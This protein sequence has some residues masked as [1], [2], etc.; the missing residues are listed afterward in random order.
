MQRGYFHFH[1]C[2]TTV[3]SPD[4]LAAIAH[5]K[6][7]SDLVAKI[8]DKMIKAELPLKYHI[9][10]AARELYPKLVQ[11]LAHNVSA[12]IP[13][14]PSDPNYLDHIHTCVNQK[15]VHSWKH[16]DACVRP[17]CPYCRMAKGSGFCDTTG[18][19][20]VTVKM[21]EEDTHFTLTV[22]P[23]P[24]RDTPSSLAHGGN[25]K[26]CTLPSI[27]SRAICFEL[28]RRKINLR[29]RQGQT[30]SHGGNPDLLYW[31]DSADLLGS[32]VDDNIKK[33]LKDI[34]AME[35]I[36]S[37]NDEPCQHDISLATF[38]HFL[39]RRNCMVTENCPPLVAAT[40]SNQA[41]YAMGTGSS[42][43]TAN[44]YATLSIP[45][46]MSLLTP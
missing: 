1:A 32:P 11:P 39:E 40:A 45:F 35:N 41:V 36:A 23:V 5:S 27:E 20:L 7:F 33:V 2:V 18:S 26:Q 38:K 15:N 22:E 17:N 12:V 25:M 42:A 34:Q 13:P 6:I 8:Y 28:Q 16:T 24:E 44:M 19:Y 37:E 3:L 29:D 14:L 9:E 10:G 43:K 46:S 30:F 21:K 4:I 31:L